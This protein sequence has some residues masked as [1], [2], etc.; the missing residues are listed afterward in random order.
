MKPMTKRLLALTVTALLLAALTVPVSADVVVTPWDYIAYT[1]AGA[2]L[3]GILVAAVVLVTVLL[4][5]FF[6]GKKRGG[7]K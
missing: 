7:K 4:I 5:R 3:A 1:P 6:F 2:I